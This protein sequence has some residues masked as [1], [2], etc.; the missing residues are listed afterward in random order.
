[1]SNKQQMLQINKTMKIERED[2]NKTNKK[3]FVIIEEWR[4]TIKK[5]G[6]PFIDGAKRECKE[7]AGIDIVI[8]GFLRMEHTHNTHNA[9]L[10]IIFYAEPLDDKQELKSK[11]DEHSVEAKWMTVDEFA[12][13]PKIRGEE[14]VHWGTYL[15]KDGPIFPLTCV[16]E[17]ADEVVVPTPSLVKSC[18]STDK[19][20]PDNDEK[21]NEK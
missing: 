20:T 8:K 7:E 18:A 5:K 15:N 1:M 2:K 17:E 3:N 6:E 4:G 11:P 9:R 10:R 19:S 16:A 14:L 12:Q 21:N 13:L